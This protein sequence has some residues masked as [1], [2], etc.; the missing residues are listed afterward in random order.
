MSVVAPGLVHDAMNRLGV[1]EVQVLPGGAQKEIRLVQ[2]GSEQLIMKVVSLGSSAPESLVRAEREVELLAALS[3]EHVVQV[4]SALI[5]LGSPPVGATW[6]EEYLDGQ[7]L[8]KELGPA[9][10][11]DAAALMGLHV[12]RGL[13]VAHH[14]GV[15]HRDLSPNNVRHLSNGVFKVMD[16]GFARHTLRTGITVAGQPGTP[17]YASPEH[18]HPYSGGP[19]AASDVYCTGILMFSALTGDV[20]I[21]WRGDEADYARRLL[22]AE[23]PDLAAARPD[24]A[25]NQVALVR[26]CLHP[27]PARRYLNGAKLAAAIEA[28]S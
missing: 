1:T 12:A 24:L 11:W 14:Q 21:P 28:L 26:R 4:A 9:W 27:Q 17:G 23:I 7:D 25:P 15:V 10:T 6:L 8:S 20:P 13:A 18:L 22:K 16:F 3:S 2:R 19:T 5:E